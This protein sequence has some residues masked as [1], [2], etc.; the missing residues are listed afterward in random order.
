MSTDNIAEQAEE[1]LK[2]LGQLASAAEDRLRDVRKDRDGIDKQ[3]VKVVQGA[4]LATR[5]LQ[6]KDDTL[7]EEENQLAGALR[8]PQPTP[9]PAEPVQIHEPD[10]SEP[11]PPPAE[12]TPAP[13]PE[14]TPPPPPADETTAVPVVDQQPDRVYTRS[15]LMAMPN[16]QLQV[17]VARRCNIHVVVTND[18]RNHIIAIIFDAQP[19]PRSNFDPR[20]YSGVQWVCAFIGLII[21]IVLWTQWPE[22]PTRNMEEGGLRTFVNFVWF[23]AHAGAGFL[24]GGWIGSVIDRRRDA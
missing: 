15:E 14:P 6:D 16:E 13:E 4:Q 8:L 18:N 2:A 5:R 19:R 9:P 12:P 17:L 7:E 22:W 11:T 23:I 20:G 10:A 21:A 24:T 3:R 1:A